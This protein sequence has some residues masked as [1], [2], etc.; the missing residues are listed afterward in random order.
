MKIKVIIFITIIT[1]ILM[2]GREARAQSLSLSISPP[3]YE[4]MIKPGKTVSQVFKITNGGESVLLKTRIMELTED[5]VKDNQ[6]FVPEKWLTMGNSEI[7]LDHPF[8]LKS[9]ETKQFNLQISPPLSTNESDYYRVLQFTT[10]PNPVLDTSQSS[11]AQN[12][13]SPVLIT[14]TS[15]GLLQKSAVV[16]QFTLP[17]IMDSF[18]NLKMRIDV[19]NTGKTYIRPVGKISLGGPLGH[20][21]FDIIPRIILTSQTRTLVSDDAY[22]SLANNVT[23]SIPGFFIG[24]YTVKTEFNLDESNI[25]LSQTKTFY[26]LPWKISTGII[27]TVFLLSLII[28]RRRNK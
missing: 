11:I 16:K 5:G 28:K 13:G 12:I 18:E 9:N 15:T 25:S 22:D 24:K 20:V 26:A 19:E 1:V 8:L 14:V 10:I 21:D 3:I 27:F 2:G 17:F 4:I 23:L 6:D 7:Q